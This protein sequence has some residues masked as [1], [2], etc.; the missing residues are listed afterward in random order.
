MKP[1]KFTAKLTDKEVFNEKF[2]KYIFEIEHPYN[3][4]FKAG[5]FVSVKVS[6]DGVRRSYSICSDASVDHGFEL[7]LD[8]SPNGLGVNFFKQL[9]FGQEIEVMGPLGHFFV[10]DEDLESSRIK[11][12]AF[13]ATG[14][15]IAPFRSMVL[16]LLHNKQETRPITLYWGLRYVQDLF[17]ENEFQD[18]VEQ[19]PNFKFHPTLSKAPLE[20]SLCKGR[21]TDCLSI[22]ELSADTTY[23]LCGGTAMINDTVKVL[24]S[25][26]VNQEDIHFEKFF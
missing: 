11:E 2:T 1:Q 22:H 25:R 12:F 7:V 26:G 9:Q 23:Y 4:K 13:V 6:E 14:S 20:W 10:T 19:Y 24:E 15:G 16:D 17:W 5:Q 21:V 18:L 3:M 8:H